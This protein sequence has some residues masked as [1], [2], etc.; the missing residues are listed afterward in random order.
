MWHEHSPHILTNQEAESTC[1]WL[2]LNLYILHPD[3]TFPQLGLSN[4]GSITSE[5]SA[6]N[7]NQLFKHMHLC[8]GEVGQFPFKL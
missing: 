8:N 1:I 6:T 4:K 2:G 3:N 5:S 7:Y